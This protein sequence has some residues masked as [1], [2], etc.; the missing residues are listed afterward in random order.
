[1][2][3]GRDAEETTLNEIGE[4]TPRSMAFQLDL[5]TQISG[6]RGASFGLVWSTE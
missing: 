6:P 2:S 3:D 1:M 5:P 4:M